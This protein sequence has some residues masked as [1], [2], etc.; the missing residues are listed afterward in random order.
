MGLPCW[1]AIF[2]EAQFAP[3]RLPFHTIP[4]SRLTTSLACYLLSPTSFRV[5]ALSNQRLEAH[6]EVDPRKVLHSRLT[7]RHPLGLVTRASVTM[8]S[9]RGRALGHVGHLFISL[10]LVLR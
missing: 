1:L 8:E 10:S 3:H 7:R 4:Q 2:E 5:R 9:A 6:P